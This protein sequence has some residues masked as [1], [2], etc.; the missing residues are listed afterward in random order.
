MSLWI[1]WFDVIKK[2]MVW[3][4]S[5]LL[6]SDPNFCCLTQQPQKEPYIYF[7]NYIKSKHLLWQLKWLMIW[8]PCSH[9]TKLVNVPSYKVQVFSE[10]HKIKKQQHFVLLLSMECVRAG[11]AGAQTHRSLRHHLLHPQIW[12]LLVL[13]I[14]TSRFWDPE[15]FSKKHVVPAD[16]NS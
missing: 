7:P 5:S 1:F 10:A 16:R 9:L 11:A 6:R 14:N 4:F 15:L 8:F 3:F 13:R 12:R 2:N